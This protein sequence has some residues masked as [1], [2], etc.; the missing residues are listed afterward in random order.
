[1]VKVLDS[2]A[3]MQKVIVFGGKIV[4]RFFFVWDG[5]D[6]KDSVDWS[7]LRSVG[8]IGQYA[9]QRRSCELGLI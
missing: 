7:E 8:A 9:G 5:W 2:C 1:M 3:L 4:S 6:G